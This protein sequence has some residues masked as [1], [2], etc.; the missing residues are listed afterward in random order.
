[1]LCFTLRGLDAAEERYTRMEFPR[2][3]ESYWIEG[4]LGIRLEVYP[5]SQV[6]LDSEVRKSCGRGTIRWMPDLFLPGTSEL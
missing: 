2:A 5:R 3:G 1:M 4:R 6:Q